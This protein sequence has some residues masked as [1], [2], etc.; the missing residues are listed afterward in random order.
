[1]AKK[2][3]F[4]TLLAIF[5]MN[6]ALARAIPEQNQTQNITPEKRIA[7]LAPII[8]GAGLIITEIISDY[9]YDNFIKDPDPIEIHNEI[10]NHIHIHMDGNHDHDE[11]QNY[12]YGAENM[13]R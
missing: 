7:P 6:F 12:D 11:N 2:I 4:F 5:S 13:A 9:I 8:T 3:S 10:H 1:M